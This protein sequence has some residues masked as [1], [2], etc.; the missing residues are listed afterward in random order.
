MIATASDNFAPFM[1]PLM[2]LMDQNRALLEKSVRMVHEESL[3]FVNRRLERNAHAL[4]Q[5][6]D[7][8]GLSGLLTI[9]QEWLADS[10]RDYLEQSQKIAQTFFQMTEE[11]TTNAREAG[12]AASRA[13]G[14]M[15]MRTDGRPDGE[16]HR[17][18]P[19]SR[20]AA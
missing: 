8:Q 3:Q 11:E 14:A 12:R 6:K 17:K 15:A 13:S 5:L 10:L 19:E 20:A 9:E 16:R 18:A 4:E 2:K 1:G 7:C